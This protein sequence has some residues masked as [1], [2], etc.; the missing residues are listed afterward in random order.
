LEL[1]VG[2]DIPMQIQDDKQEIVR[3]E[4]INDELSESLEQCWHLLEECR[5]KLAANANEPDTNDR[6]AEAKNS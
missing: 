2:E 1:A 4:R 3:L 6:G 5:S